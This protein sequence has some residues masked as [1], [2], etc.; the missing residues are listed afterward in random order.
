MNDELKEILNG[1]KE[2]LDNPTTT[3]ECYD[4]RII[5]IDRSYD[6]DLDEIKTLLDYITNLQHTEDLYN[7]LLKDYDDLQQENE[8]LKEK[9]IN[10][11]LKND[12][13]M[14]VKDLKKANKKIEKLEDCKSRIEKAVEY[15]KTR[16]DSSKAGK[17]ELLDILNGRSDE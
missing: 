7:Q 14:C 17:W 13:D 1:F 8:R 5:E 11:V 12:F 15:I 3:D 9:S 6:L 2:I 10:E 16:I 4:G